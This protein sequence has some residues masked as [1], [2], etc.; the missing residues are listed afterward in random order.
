MIKLGKKAPKLFQSVADEAFTDLGLEGEAFVE[1]EFVSPLEMKNINSETRGIDKETDVLS[2]PML[3]EIMPFTKKNYR[4]DYD[5]DVDAVRIGSIII[6]KEIAKTQ[7]EEY[8]HGVRRE[9]A[10]LFLH[11]LLHL[12][13][14]DHSGEEDTKSMRAAEERILGKL[15]IKRGK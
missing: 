3:D 4:Y 2:F 9:E 6:C 10:Y 11:G 13:G 7:A 15:N 5:S 8:G 1:V 12:L 14:Y